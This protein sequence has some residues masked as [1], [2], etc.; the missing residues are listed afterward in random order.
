MSHTDSAV[1]LRGH[2]F[3]GAQE[4]LTERLDKLRRGDQRAA[5]GN[6]VELSR[7]GPLWKP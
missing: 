1:A 6:V 5:N 4:E 3:G 7:A 2:L